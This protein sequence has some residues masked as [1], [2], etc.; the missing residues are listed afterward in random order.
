MKVDRLARLFT[1]P[2]AKYRQWLLIGQEYPNLGKP[3]KIYPQMSQMNT[4]F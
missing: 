3:E 2:D 1:C 4:D